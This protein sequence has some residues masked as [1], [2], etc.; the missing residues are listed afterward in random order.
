[1]AAVGVLHPSPFPPTLVMTEEVFVIWHIHKSRHRSVD[2]LMC[3]C[4]ELVLALWQ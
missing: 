3:P 1:M 2:L 4:I